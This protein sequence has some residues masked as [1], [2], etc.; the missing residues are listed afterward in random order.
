VTALPEA[1]PRLET[2]TVAAAP[3][4]EGA[5]GDRVGAGLLLLLQLLPGGGRRIPPPPPPPPARA[6]RTAACSAAAV[7]ERVMSGMTGLV[8]I[9]GKEKK[10]EGGEP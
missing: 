6:L 8:P 9:V 3:G 1:S 7:W 4:L 5:K 2:T 10:G